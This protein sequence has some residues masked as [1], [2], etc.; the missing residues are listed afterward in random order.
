MG[1]SNLDWGSSCLFASADMGDVNLFE[2]WLDKKKLNIDVQD[3]DGDTP[4]HHAARRGHINLVIELLKKGALLTSNKKK[5]TALQDAY[6]F[7]QTKIA[8]EITKFVIQRN[9]VKNILQIHKSNK[10][11]NQKQQELDP[12]VNDFIQY[13][14]KK[15]LDR[16][17]FR[18][19]AKHTRRANALIIAAQR[20]STIKEFKDLLN[21]Q[22]N[23]CKGNPANPISER[24][25]D[26]RWSEVMKNKY[27]DPNKSLFYKTIHNF[28]AERIANNNINTT[29]VRSAFHR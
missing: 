26:K 25:M 21:N 4:L 29:N 7:N 10:V 9:S 2:Y 3:E 24:I 6:A 11:D 27:K 8:N 20:C 28:L 12:L 15:Y 17:I 18:F 16:N 22:L 1:K 23:L 5:R 14:R 13:L 19:P